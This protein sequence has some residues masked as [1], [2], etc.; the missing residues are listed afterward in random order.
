MLK[1]GNMLKIVLGADFAQM[2]KMIQAS[3]I[4]YAKEQ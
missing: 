3:A 4:P 1:P 2:I